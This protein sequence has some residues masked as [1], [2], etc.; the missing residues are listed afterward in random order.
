[1]SCILVCDVY[2]PTFNFYS[3]ENTSWLFLSVK[4]EI[5]MY[6]MFSRYDVYFAAS[7]SYSRGVKNVL[8]FWGIW[9]PG[10]AGE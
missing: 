2:F 9:V 3:R 4:I 8:R 5:K 1:M 6:V 7:R 10:Y